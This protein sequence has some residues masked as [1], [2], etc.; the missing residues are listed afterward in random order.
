[1]DLSKKSIVRLVQVFP[2]KEWNLL[3][4]MTLWV[5]EHPSRNMLLLIGL[6][7]VEPPHLEKHGSNLLDVTIPAWESYFIGPV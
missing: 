6:T 3:K 1:M 7:V 5:V 4:E 2:E